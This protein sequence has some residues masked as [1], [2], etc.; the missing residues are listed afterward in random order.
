MYRVITLVSFFLLFFTGLAPG[1]AGGG[2][3][4]RVIWQA[5][6]LGKPAGGLQPGPNGLFYLPSGNKL[7][8]VDDRGQKLWEAAVASGGGPLLFNAYG[9]I[10]LP[11]NS[12]IQEIKVNGSHGWSFT[13]YQEKSK[14]AAQLAAGPGGRL[15]L[16]LPA[17]LYALD[18]AGKYQWMAYWE[19]TDANRTQAVSGRQILACAGSSRAVFAV[20]GNKKDG[21]SLVAV[22]SRGET[23]WRCWLGSIKS[24]YLEPGR[25]GRLYA[26]VNPDR[27]DRSNRGAVY[28]FDT[29]SGRV[30]W[31][32]NVPYDNL[33]AP[34]LSDH[35]L[36]YFCAGEKLTVLNRS[37]GTEAWW[38]KLSKAISQPAVNENSQRVY[39]GTDDSRL[40]AVSPEGRLEWEL[41]LDGKVSSKPLA[42]PGGYIYAATDKGSIYKIQ[43][44]D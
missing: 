24:V 10:F 4:P 21:Y 22:D 3:A 2:E 9:S 37:D 8:A 40:L 12:M 38:Q 36:L 44:N 35:G 32:Y 34:T 42:A 7:T 31:K 15:Y 16:P 27:L 17:G 1:A 5:S 43:D 33:T 25:D 19:S 30:V 18:T 23:A 28:A 26:T 39:L 13:A 6:R 14:S 29:D 41:T 11:G 20:Y